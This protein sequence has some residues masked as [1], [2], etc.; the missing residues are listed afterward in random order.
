MVVDLS[1]VSGALSS[2]K[3]ASDIAKGFFGLA[4]TAESQSQVVELNQMILD[5]QRQAM[6][7]LEERHALR[8]KVEELEGE[9]RRVVD[10]TAIISQMKRRAPFYFQDGD[11][12]PFCTRCVETDRRRVHMIKTIR[13]EQRYRIWACPACKTEVAD[14]QGVAV[15]AAGAQS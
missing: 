12:D 1:V 7:D 14:M 2:L 10:D 13:T 8:R 9:L 15:V 5:A 3:A 6:D 11:Q 4:V